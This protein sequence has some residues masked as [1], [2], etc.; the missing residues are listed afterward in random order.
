VAV[1]VGLT[2]LPLPIGQQAIAEARAAAISDHNAIPFATLRSQLDGGIATFELRQIVGNLFLLLP[3]GV[4]GPILTPHLRTVSAI[5]LAGAAVATVIE[6][7]QLAIATLYGF[8]LRVADVD[9]V[10]L[11]TVGVLTG[12]LLWRAL[13]ATASVDSDHAVRGP[14]D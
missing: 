1:V 12:Y 11:N 3:L 13:A 10:L 9:D 2:F 7:G 5:L 6:L 14:A 8:P 4:Y